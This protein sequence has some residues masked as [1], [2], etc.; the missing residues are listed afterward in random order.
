MGDTDYYK[1]LG[2]DKTASMDDIKKAYRKLSMKHHPDR[3]RNDPDSTVIFQNVSAA[4]DTLGDITKKQ[5]YDMEQSN[6][7]FNP[8][9][10]G[11]APMA[12]DI[13]NMLFSELVDLV[14]LCNTCLMA[15]S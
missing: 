3:N 9:A 8:A 11:G 7:L 2:V 6:P 1:I 14:D 13:F 4:Y 12:N 5:Q 10:G 15:I